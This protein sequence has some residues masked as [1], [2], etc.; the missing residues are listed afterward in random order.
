[1]AAINKIPQHVAFI[2]DGNGRWARKRGL[3]RVLGH[4]K[5]V[6]TI[7]EIARVARELKIKYLTLYAF[8]KENWAR[9]KREIDF[10][11]KLL[12]NYLDSELEEMMSN[13]IRFNTIGKV[14]ELPASIQEK[15][16]RNVRQTEKNR[17]LLLT[18]ALSYSSRVEITDAAKRLCE[19]VKSGRLQ[20][21]E[22]NED[23]LS[24]ELYTAG[25]PDPDLLIRTSGELRISNFLLW[26][27]SYTEIYVSE[28]YWPDFRKED[29]I[30]AVRDY[31]KRERRFGRT[32]TGRLAK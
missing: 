4:E 10:L 17:D 29:F 8:S 6:N 12:S 7:R 27:I 13:H 30:E 3:A 31:Q 19:Q 9:P 5:G 16:R 20:L 11:M 22:I 21:E 24:R 18:L 15:I 1:M 26:Q 25:I 32:E 23:R 28:K 14:E 2:M